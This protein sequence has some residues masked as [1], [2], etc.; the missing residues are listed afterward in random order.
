M[1]R[2]GIVTLMFAVLAAIISIAAFVFPDAQKHRDLRIVLG[3]LFLLV[4][5]VLG[6]IGGA[7][8]VLPSPPDIQIAAMT[9]STPTENVAA[10]VQMDTPTKAPEPPNAGRTP[11]L[12]ATPEP[13]I[14]AVPSTPFEHRFHQVSLRNVGKPESG[15]LGLLAGIK[16]L[17]GVDFEIGWLVTTLSVGDPSAPEAVS[18]NTDEAVPSKVHLLLQGSWATSYDREFGS[19]HLLFLD[20]RSISVPL[21]VGQNIRDWSQANVP[22]TDPVAREAWR[23]TGWDGHTVGV[24]DALTVEIPTE[25]QNTSL[26]QI[27]VRDES[28]SKLGSPNPGIHLWAITLEE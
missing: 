23:G 10:P 3:I 20:G 9:E 27:E 12:P 4:T 25:Y 26:T 5:M 1:D 16:T 14:E 19:V 21:I 6:G 8:L 24:V 7:L 17:V 22:L 2:S 28:M 13:D 11:V 15:N 18:L